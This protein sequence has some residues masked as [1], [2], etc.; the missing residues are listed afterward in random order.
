MHQIKR[1]LDSLPK[2][3]KFFFLAGLLAY[4][5]LCYRYRI[6]MGD[7]GDFVKA[8]KMITEDIDPYSNLM[9]VNSPVS[10][11]IVYYLSH[12]LPFIFFPLFWQLLN[13]IG[14]FFFTKT[15]IR[16]DLHHILL[17]A[18][19]CFAFLNVTRALFANVQVTGLVLGLLAISL[20]ATKS[21]RPAIW[22]ILPSWL[23]LEIKPQIALGF[24]ILILFNNGVQK[25]R[26]ILLVV[27]LAI[28]HIFVE[29]AFVGNIHKL[30]LQKLLRYSSASLEE[31][32]EISYWKVISIYAGNP[33][34]IRFFSILCT[35]L[36]LILV[37]YFSLRAKPNWS[38]FLCLLLPFQNTY[39]HLYD[40]ALLG[41]IFSIGV[42]VYRSFLMILPVGLLMLFF[43]IKVDSFTLVALI[44]LTLMLIF[45]RNQSN[46]RSSLKFYALTVSAGVVLQ[47]L[48][49]N[50]SQEM[51]IA[52]ALVIPLASMLIFLR[53]QIVNLLE[54]NFQ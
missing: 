45:Q 36:T 20:Q 22:V 43:P 49:R 28:S 9:Y 53:K 16:K 15:V 25:M 40:L 2:W 32:Y 54:P 5:I 1:I 29:F 50:E 26:T 42:Y 11:F 27:F 23:A 31:G 41:I 47:Y 14:L 35:A 19:T 30:W 52:C 24:S 51:Q 46:F 8:G 44:V 21:N 18:F 39:L 13:V 48:T 34:E 33:S 38:I 17:F 4:S 6:H 37:I 3:E 10:A 12:L 7:F